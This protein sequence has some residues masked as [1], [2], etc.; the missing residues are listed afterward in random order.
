MNL[1][2][3][4]KQALASESNLQKRFSKIYEA[5][6]FWGRICFRKANGGVFSL[7]CFPEDGALVLEHAENQREA[8]LNRFEG[9]DMFYLEDMTEEEIFRAMLREIEGFGPGE[10]SDEKK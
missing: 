9:G 7:W 5:T 10:V 6:D 3:Q 2:E 1:T 8:E 4:R